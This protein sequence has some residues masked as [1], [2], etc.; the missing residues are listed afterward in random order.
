MEG[1]GAKRESNSRLPLYD[2]AFPRVCRTVY[3]EPY[4]LHSKEGKGKEAD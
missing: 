1:T 3:Y 4:T 2:P